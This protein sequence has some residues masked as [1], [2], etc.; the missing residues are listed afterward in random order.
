MSITTELSAKNNQTSFFL[1]LVNK[2]TDRIRAVSKIAENIIRE[3]WEETLVL[4]VCEL[5]HTSVGF[6]AVVLTIPLRG[7]FSIYIYNK[8]IEKLQKVDSSLK[9]MLVF[10]L[11]IDI[12]FVEDSKGLLPVTIENRIILD[13]LLPITYAITSFT[14]ASIGT[15][16]ILTNQPIQRISGIFLATIGLLAFNSSINNLVHL[17]ENL[18]LF[19]TLN[20]SNRQGVLKHRALTTL[21]Y[22][23]SCNAVIIDGVDDIPYGFPFNAFL[24]RTCHTRYFKVDSSQS[25]CNALADFPG[26]LN[27][28]SINAHGNTIKGLFLAPNYTTDD[29]NDREY[30]CLNQFLVKDAQVFLNGCSSA[31]QGPIKNQTVAESFSLHLPGKE[32]IGFN[33]LYN[34]FLTYFSYNEGKMRQQSLFFKKEIASF[35]KEKNRYTASYVLT[36]P[37]NAIAYMNGSK[38]EHESLS[39]T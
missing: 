28:L 39:W 11:A 13:L 33:A 19:S 34:P 10:L 32:V 6:S 18:S 24:Y 8:L 26:N 2:G 14:I 5:S 15:S 30:S 1:T 20:P 21:D 22:P 38:I 23:K 16:K 31:S 25:F 9:I 17:K 3:T 35:N 12:L 29:L 27:I 4:S 7:L 37:F 36:Y